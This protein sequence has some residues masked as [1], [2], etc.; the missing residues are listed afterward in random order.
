VVEEVGVGDPVDGGVDGE[1][2]EEEVGDVADAVGISL[3]CEDVLGRGG[4][5]RKGR[6]RM[7]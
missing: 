4:C 1:E 7:R 3:S 2:E 6:M 5:S